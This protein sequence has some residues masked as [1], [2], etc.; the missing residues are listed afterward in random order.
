[1]LSD[2]FRRFDELIRKLK[3]AGATVTE[4]D[5]VSQLFISLPSSYD[6]VTTAME[7]LSDDQLKLD[8]VKARLLAEE[9][10]R[11]GRGHSSSVESLNTAF[12]GRSRQFAGRCYG[13]G[14]AGVRDMPA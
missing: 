4:L 10:K 2:H 1:M 8:V 9:Q 7:N 6:A 5:V 12:V 11:N 13:C 14:D 3:N